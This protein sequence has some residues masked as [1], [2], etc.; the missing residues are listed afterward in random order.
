MSRIFESQNNI[1][2]TSRKIVFVLHRHEL[3]SPEKQACAGNYV[4]DI[5]TSDI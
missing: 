2:F 4:I 5:L 1:V 3:K